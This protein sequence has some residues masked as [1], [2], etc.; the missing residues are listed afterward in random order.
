M[1]AS[2]GRTG[3]R[4]LALATLLAAGAGFGGAALAA[5]WYP[6][7]VESW[8][9]PFDMSSPRTTVDYVPLKKADKPWQLCVSFP[10]MKDAYW[11]AVDYGIADEAKALG[12]KMHLV[13]AG[14]YTELNK[15][16]S[17][18]EDCVANGAQAVII[19]AISYDGL[20]NLVHEI[21]GKGIPVID[22]INGI[23][24]K[25]ISAKSLVSFGEMGAKAGEYVAKL[26]PKGSKAVKVAWFPGPAGA[27]WVEAGNKGFMD[28]VKDS[29]V[30]VVETKYGDTGKEVQSKL[31]EDTLQAHPDLDYIVGTAVTAEAAVPVLRSRG[32]S[33]QVKVVS[34]YFTPGVYQGIRRGQILAAPTD[35]TVIQ[36]RIAVDQAVRILEGKDYI[37]HAGPKLYVISKDNINS[38]DRAAA[39]A[40]D[41][42]TPVFSVGE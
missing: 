8:N 7:T 18:I 1:T 9:P 13:E 24:S 41:G 31:V 14:G 23:S 20:N 35:S 36:G 17:Q 33:D 10:H 6:Y 38:F 32:L 12:V 37:K 11:L 28:A 4:G 34:Y 27:G 21:H 2:F 30:Q 3:S 42:F 5:D 16:I 25:E 29:A 15:Q 40:P 22:V 26:H 19:G 39:L